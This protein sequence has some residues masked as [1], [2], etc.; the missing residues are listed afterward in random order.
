MLS[1]VLPGDGG[2]ES[3]AKFERY[4]I[5]LTPT[6]SRSALRL[7]RD[8]HDAEDLV[9]EAMLRAFV[10]IG[11]LREGTNES[12]WLY[13]ILH[14]TWIDRHRRRQR[15]PIERCVGMFND[16]IL[17]SGVSHASRGLRSAELDALEWIPDQ[18]VRAALEALPDSL[19]TVVY[20]ADIAGIGCKEIADIMN[21]PLGTVLS[22]LH[23]ARSR[24]RATLATH[25]SVR[26]QASA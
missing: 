15:R 22:R 3:V 26:H 18:E 20:Y 6:I 2:D 4:V 9:Q 1:T 7:T 17:A 16:H 10:G 5:P 8:R 12:A 14:N 21:T 24:L 23:R 19:R 25:Y 11:S 13:R